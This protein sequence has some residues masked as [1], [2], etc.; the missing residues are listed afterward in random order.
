MSSDSNRS[1]FP[2][3]DVVITFPDAAAA[4]AARNGPLLSLSSHYACD[5]VQFTAT[6]DPYG[7]RVGS[8]GGTAAALVDFGG[9]EP[10][11]QMLR[12]AS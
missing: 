3:D 1:S 6:A 2:F 12:A 10:Q 4:T 8:G 9:N 5:E 11:E 7:A